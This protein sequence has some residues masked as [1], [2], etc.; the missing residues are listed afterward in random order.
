MK[1]EFGRMK[2]SLTFCALRFVFFILLPSS[3][4]NGGLDT[5][6]VLFYYMIAFDK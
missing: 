2:F 3:F 6:R 1:A 4:H 5:V